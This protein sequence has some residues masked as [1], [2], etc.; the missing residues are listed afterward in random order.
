MMDLPVRKKPKERRIEN[1]TIL[2]IQDGDKVAVRKRPSRGLLAGMYEFPN[3]EGH[4]EEE[5][6]GMDQTL[7]G[8]TAAYPSS[9]EFQTH[10]F[11]CGMENDRICDPCGGTG[12]KK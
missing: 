10:L 7:S 1:R 6:S 4:L 3:L 9:G 5:G 2:V 8:G 12:R 11:P